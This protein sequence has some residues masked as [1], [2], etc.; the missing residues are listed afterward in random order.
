[1][2]D[3]TAI[4]GW[5]NRIKEDGLQIPGP[6]HLIAWSKLELEA[7]SLAKLPLVPPGPAKGTG[8]HRQSS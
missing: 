7:N 3:L 2:V 6:R 1:M 8:F 5:I 4:L